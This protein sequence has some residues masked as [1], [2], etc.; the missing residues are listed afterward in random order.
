[1]KK[2]EGIAMFKTETH[3][4]TDESSRCGK[5]PAREM[6]ALYHAAGFTTLFISDHFQKSAFE[7]MGETLRAEYF[8]QEPTMKDSLSINL[9]ASSFISVLPSDLLF[10]IIFWAITLLRR[11]RSMMNMN[12]HRTIIGRYVDGFNSLPPCS[13]LSFAVT[14]NSASILISS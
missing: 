11:L 7:K 13:F 3:M 2:K 8:G 12:I 4:H 6:V 10:S 5:V 14:R 9:F 1:M